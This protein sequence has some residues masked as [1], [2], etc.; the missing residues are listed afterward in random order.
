M[1]RGSSGTGVLDLLL[2]QGKEVSIEFVRYR[3]NECSS[4]ARRRK[5]ERKG[6]KGGKGFIA[7]FNEQIFLYG[8]ENMYE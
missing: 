7:G 8:A 6:R 5:D 3:W 4:R 1:L 2:I